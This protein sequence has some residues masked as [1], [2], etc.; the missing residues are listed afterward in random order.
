V[1]FGYPIEA[2]QNNWLHD[3][4]CSAVRTIHEIVDQKRKYPPWPTILPAGHRGALKLRTG[5]R[6]RFKSYNSVLRMFDKVDRDL[7]L[8][9]LEGENRVAELLS[10]ACECLTL[11]DLPQDLRKPIAELFG[12]AFELLSDLG[13]RDEQ[14][15]AI[16]SAVSDHV[17]PFCGTEHFDPPGPKREALDHYLS[18]NRY[19]LASANLRNLVPMCHKCNSSYKLS[20]DLLRCSDGSRRVAFDPYVHTSLRVSLDESDPFN[21]S[22]P[23]TPKWEIRF[24]PDVPAVSTWDQVFSVRERYRRNHLD[25]DFR[26][27]LSSFGQWARA[28][29]INADTGE[30]LVAALGRYE[31]YLILCGM[32]DRAFLKAAVFRMLRRHCEDGHQRLIEQLRD[33]VVFATASRLPLRHAAERPSAARSIP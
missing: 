30:A 5:L 29:D 9:A 4:L 23:N 25:P 21:G 18:R 22:T 19:T 10:G 31:E 17:C 2:T 32:H 7:V 24:D 11:H 28:G 14:Y 8:D 20:T 33:V 12:L 15:E 27:W 6:D 26:R 13:V 16:Y 1:L 3:C